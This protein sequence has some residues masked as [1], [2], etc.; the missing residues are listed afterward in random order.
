M[1]LYRPNLSKQSFP[2]C[3]WN[4]GVNLVK[5]AVTIGFE[6]IPCAEQPTS[7]TACLSRGLYTVGSTKALA[8]VRSTTSC[9]ISCL[10]VSA[11]AVRPATFHFYPETLGNKVKFD[12]S[13]REE[14][15]TSAANEPCSHLLELCIYLECN[16]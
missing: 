1:A 4:F 5:V 8:V 7:A 11:S 2:G 15:A 6:K 12:D 13:I 10:T 9:L 3:Q 14:R 16:N